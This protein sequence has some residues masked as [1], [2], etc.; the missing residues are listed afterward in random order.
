MPWFDA[1]KR[2]LPWRR[3]RDPYRI[4]VSEIMLQQTQVE[5]VRE[6][7]RRF[8]ARFPDL[9]SLAQ[10]PLDDVLSEWSGLGYYRRARL[11]HRAAQVVWEEHDGVVPRDPEAFLALPGVGRYTAGAVLSI[12]FDLPRPILDGNVIRVFTRLLRLDADPRG[13]AAQKTLWALAEEV[14]PEARAGDFNQSLMELGATVCRPTSPGCPVCPVSAVCA[15]YAEGDMERFPRPKVKV[16]PPETQRVAVL[17]ERGD[18]RFLVVQRPDEGLLAGLWEL[19]AEDLEGREA[20]EV[21][22]GLARRLGVRAKV[23]RRG[24]AEHRFSHRLWKVRTYAA[25]TRTTKTPEGGRWVTEAELKGLGVPTA[26]RKILRAA[27]SQ[28]AFPL[29]EGE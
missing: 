23:A 20:E 4:W 6:P 29:F 11:L 26:S 21:A 8:L 18:G 9:P 15:A 24:E 10:A 28:P 14:L 22:R 1:H 27:R 3:T 2:D 25:Q 17:L 12:A 19:P 7:Y 5:T 16:A 13:S